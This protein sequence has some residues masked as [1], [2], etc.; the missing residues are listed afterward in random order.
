MPWLW[1]T[2]WTSSESGVAHTSHRSRLVIPVSVW[3]SSVVVLIQTLMSVLWILTFAPM[4]FVK[5]CEAAIAATATVATSLMLLEPT[6][7]VSRLLIFF[8]YCG[9]I[10]YHYVDADLTWQN[11]GRKASTSTS[12]SEKAENR[13]WCFSESLHSCYSYWVFSCNLVG[14]YC[15]LGSVSR[16]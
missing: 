12:Y 11:L 10:I 4:G 6:V 3:L 16:R 15:C 2:S 13:E 14:E 8:F 5:T 9:W 7:W 1:M